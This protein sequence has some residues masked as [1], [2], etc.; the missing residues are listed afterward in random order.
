MADQTHGS[1]NDKQ[2][3]LA[4]AAFVVAGTAGVALLAG[5]TTGRETAESVTGEPRAT[6]SRVDRPVFTPLGPNEQ[7]AGS[8]VDRPIVD[9]VESSDERSVVR[10]DFV[11][12]PAA[13]P[14]RE[15]NRAYHAG[16]FDEAY[17]YLEAEIAARP[18]RA[19]SHYMLGLTARRVGRL[20]RATSA[21]AQSA[22]INPHSIRTFVNLSR[23]QNDNGEFENALVSAEAAL[24]ID[25][26]SSDA[27]YQKG[28]SLFNLG[29]TEQ[30]FQVLQTVV[31]RDAEMGQA[32]NLIGLIHLRAERDGPALDALRLAATLI[33]EVAYVQN[34]LGLAL[35]RGG[36][37]FDAAEAFRLARALDDA[38]GGAAL[39]LARVE[40]LIPDG[41]A[42]IQ[43]ASTEAD[44]ADLV[45]LETASRP[46]VATPQP[47][48]TE[49]TPIAELPDRE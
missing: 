29:R 6:R 39:S 34:N 16:R 43:L 28:R 31:T 8:P 2:L 22:R 20:D 9:R 44:R 33:P 40:A 12:D 15:G 14:W 48:S 25:A 47:A 24:S 30:A 38:Q 7:F 23:V 45:S 41:G 11:I 4:V 46:S 42:E 37:L 18:G 49:P 17:A 3:L 19:Y 1:A 5:L 26:D 21:L 35:E 32:H 36:R 27:E 10:E 13:D